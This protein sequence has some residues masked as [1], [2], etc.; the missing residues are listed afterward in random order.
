MSDFIFKHSNAE[1]TYTDENGK[2]TTYKVCDV[3]GVEQKTNYGFTV[4]HKRSG[5]EGSYR[6]GLCGKCANKILP[7]LEETLEDIKDTVR[8]LRELPES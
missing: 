4:S 2:K 5:V 1:H 7:L 3:C 8:E 6:L